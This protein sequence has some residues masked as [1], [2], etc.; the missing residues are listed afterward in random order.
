M[1]KCEKRTMVRKSIYIDSKLVKKIEA[2]AKR[3]NRKFSWVAVNI[4]D[5]ALSNE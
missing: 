4:L 5:K 3:E 1:K 2:R